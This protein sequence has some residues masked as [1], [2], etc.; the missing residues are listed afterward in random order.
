MNTF[1]I[2]VSPGKGVKL[3]YRRIFRASLI[4]SVLIFSAS[5]VYGFQSGGRLLSTGGVTQIEG[6]A[7]GGLVPWALI[8]GYGTRDQMGATI[9]YTQANPSNFSLSSMGVALGIYDRVE[10][11]VAQQRFGLGNTAPGRT[12]SQHVVGIKL[13]LDG[14]AVFD[15]DKLWPQIAVGLQYKNNL[16]F[17]IVPRALGAKRSSGIDFYI[18]A[19]KLYLGAV[20]G[21]NLLLNGTLRATKANQLGILGFGG[22]LSDRYGVHFESS[23]GVFLNDNLLAGAEYRH[24]PN[25]LSIFKEDAFSDIFMAYV[26]NKHVAVTA[27]YARFGNI[28]NKPNQNAL[29]LSLQLGF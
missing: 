28:A 5:A 15:Q 25:N 24:K 6:S 1:R 4:A 2:F 7:G 20:A 21:R 3:A 19:T 27:A 9:F 12:I 16:D 23:V 8:S 14:D 26:P 17:D 11:S 29:Y 13:K 22:D 10:L 18:A